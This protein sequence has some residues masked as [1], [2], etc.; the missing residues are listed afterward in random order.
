MNVN[1][2]LN[3][4]YIEIN[5]QEIFIGDTINEIEIK[6]NLSLFVSQENS[7]STIISEGDFQLH[8][9][10]D[11]LYMWTISPEKS[12]LT[13]NSKKTKLN[14]IKFNSFLKI[15]FSKNIKWEFNQALTFS[16]QVCIRL[17]NNVD[18]IFWFDKKNRK[19][20][21]EKVGFYNK[22]CG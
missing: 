15:L 18:F 1:Y 20:C 10:K 14:K 11:M 4:N 6:T 16:D 8:F 3:K 2:L 22:K 19:G 13:S 12:F 5:G 9:K 17:K 21:L 7:D